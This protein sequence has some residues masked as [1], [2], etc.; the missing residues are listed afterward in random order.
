MSL[1]PMQAVPLTRSIPREAVTRQRGAAQKHGP[2][3]VISGTRSKGPVGAK[4]RSRPDYCEPRASWTVC[5]A[6]Q[7][8]CQANTAGASTALSAAAGPELAI[9]NC[10]GRAKKRGQDHATGLHSVLQ[11]RDTVCTSGTESCLPPSSLRPGVCKSGQEHVPGG[12]ARQQD[13]GEHL[14]AFAHANSASERRCGA[15]RR[16]CELGRKGDDELDANGEPCEPKCKGNEKP[17]TNRCLG[18]RRRKG[19]EEL[20]A[21]LRLAMFASAADAQRVCSPLEGTSGNEPM[22]CTSTPWR[23][24]EHNGSGRHL[25]AAHKQQVGWAAWAEVFCGDAASGSWLHADPIAGVAKAADGVEKAGRAGVAV[26]YVVAFQGGAAKD[27][28]RRYAG[29]F[30]RSLRER[31][32]KWWTTMLEPFRRR[33][34]C[35]RPASCCM[36]A[37]FRATCRCPENSPTAQ[38]HDWV[39]LDIVVHTRLLLS[40]PMQCQLFA[41]PGSGTVSRL[42]RPWCEPGINAPSMTMK[43]Q[44]VHGPSPSHPEMLVFH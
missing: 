17:D 20:E 39:E 42:G 5:T 33:Q 29:S 15:T 2:G 19:D 10:A 4:N 11:S 14:V 27:V 28:T 24:Q 23:G 43:M 31:E 13:N 12:S 38:R 30:M 22:Q 6:N 37:F 7:G 21:Q 32:E 25:G 44:H 8:L 34:V 18:E 16:R 41:L 3:V 36:A 9:S 35:L 26:A 1:F 40:F